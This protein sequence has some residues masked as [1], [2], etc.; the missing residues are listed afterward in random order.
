MAVFNAAQHRA[1][2]PD[3]RTF[4]KGWYR[5]KCE[6]SESK[7]SSSG[8]QMVTL[9]IRIVDSISGHFINAIQWENLTIGHPSPKVS[10][11]AQGKLTEIM[12]AAG[13]PEL[14]VW[15]ELGEKGTDF[16]MS[17]G[18]SSQTGRSYAIYRP[19]SAYLEVAAKHQPTQQF[20][21]QTPVIPPA[22]PIDDYLDDVPY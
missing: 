19:L 4:P 1:E 15:G 18:I 2:N 6:M 13:V 16:A 9:K 3:D 11:I 22:P 10:K 21:S 7:P 8:Y 20:E 12:L 17:I 5:V 14:D